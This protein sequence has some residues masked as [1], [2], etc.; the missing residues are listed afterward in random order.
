MQFH[1]PVKH[2][3]HRGLFPK[4]TLL[5]MKLTAAIL[6]AACLQVSARSNA[7]QVTHIKDNIKKIICISN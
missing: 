6:L 7:Q 5:I 4:K 3:F 1:G 2:A